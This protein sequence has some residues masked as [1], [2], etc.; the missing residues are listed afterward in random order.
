LRDERF[1]I[2]TNIVAQAT[3]LLWTPELVE[4]YPEAQGWVLAMNTLFGYAGS[5][6]LSK[7]LG[8]ANKKI[9]QIVSDKTDNKT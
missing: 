6:V 9:D 3:L 8:T 5:S 7:L 4:K 2:L 1:A